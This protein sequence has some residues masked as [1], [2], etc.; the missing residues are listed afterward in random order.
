[1]P[2]SAVCSLEVEEA[3]SAMANVRGDFVAVAETR[4]RVSGKAKTQEGKSGWVDL[5]RACVRAGV[6]AGGQAGRSGAE[7]EGRWATG[8]THVEQWLFDPLEKQPLS[9]CGLALVQQPKQ[10]AI[11]VDVRCRRQ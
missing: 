11:L 3:Y 2:P 6:R 8:G 4:G 5:G 10:V 1:M 9:N 7:R